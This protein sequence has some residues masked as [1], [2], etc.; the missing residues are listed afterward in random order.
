[1]T[2]CTDKGTITAAERRRM[3]LESR[4]RGAAAQHAR[5]VKGPIVDRYER[6]IDI[7]AQVAAEDAERRRCRW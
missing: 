6:K 4:R 7:R 2:A 1:M 5:H 3:A